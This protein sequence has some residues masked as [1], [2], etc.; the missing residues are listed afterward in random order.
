MRML[1]AIYIWVVFYINPYSGRR[2]PILFYNR[3]WSGLE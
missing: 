3:L 2:V 1:K